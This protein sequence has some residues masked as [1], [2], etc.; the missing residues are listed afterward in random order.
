MRNFDI[1]TKGIRDIEKFLLEQPK[2]ANRAAVLAI[3]EVTRKNY[4][5]SRKMIMDKV[6]LS[7]SYLDGADSGKPRLQI[8]KLAKENDLQGIIR[9]RQRAT[10][11]ARFDA[12]QL[13]RPGK[14][15]RA[16]AGV[17]VKVGSQRKKIPNAFLIKLKRGT[18]G[19]GNMGLAIRLPSG[20]QIR[21]KTIQA[22]PL[23]GNGQRTT[24]VYLLYGPSV[25]QVF[26]NV[27]ETLLPTI[28]RQLESEF[29][30][31]FRRLKGGQ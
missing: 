4:V 11:L 22:R 3:N 20:E 17:S 18:Q 25:Q 21:N 10:S 14:S 26:S 13:Y 5:L 2:I 30:R 9:G 24:D 28:D 7:K 1:R 15:G 12:K 19:E 31:Q 23:G 6:N 29:I 8:I 27:A 16:K